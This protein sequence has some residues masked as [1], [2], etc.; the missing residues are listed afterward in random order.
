MRSGKSYLPGLWNSDYGDDGD[1]S[2]YRH[3]TSAASLRSFEPQGDY[4]T[5]RLSNLTRDYN[6][7]AI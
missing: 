1:D 3:S 4:F 7:C 5:I 6:L 2:L